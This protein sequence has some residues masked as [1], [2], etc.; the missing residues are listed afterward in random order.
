M[1][2]SSVT[3]SGIA[4]WVLLPTIVIGFD[5]TTVFSKHGKPI[6]RWQARSK[7]SFS[8]QQKWFGKVKRHG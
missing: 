2:E 8:G 4:N 5:L 3:I 7:L 1:P 6:R